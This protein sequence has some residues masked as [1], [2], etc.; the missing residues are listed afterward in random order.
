MVSPV[1]RVVVSLALLA[2]VLLLCG[3]CKTDDD[4]SSPNGRP[5]S[6]HIAT[7][8]IW[9]D[10]QLYV[11]VHDRT[12]EQLL[13]VRQ[14]TGTGVTTFPPL[15]ERI[16]VTIAQ[17]SED[18][19]DIR[20]YLD[21]PAGDWYMG[22][23]LQQSLRTHHLT[24]DITYPPGDNAYLS[25]GTDGNNTG[26][27]ISAEDSTGCRIGFEVQCSAPDSTGSI[28]GMVAGRDPGYCGW[29]LDLPVTASDC[30]HYALRLDQVA[31]MHT[32]GFSQPVRNLSVNALRGSHPQSIMEWSAN[33]Q[34]DSR[35]LSIPFCPEFPASKYFVA[36]DCYASMYYC[37]LEQ[38]VSQLPSS[39]TVPEVYLSATYDSYRLEVRD[40][41][42]VGTVDAIEA[43]WRQTTLDGPQCYWTVAARPGITT[44][45]RPT[46][47]DSLLTAFGIA[48][49]ELAPIGVSAEDYDV[50]HDFDAFVALQFRRASSIYT[51][52]HSHSYTTH[53][54]DASAA[55]EAIRLHHE[56]RRLR[57][58]GTSR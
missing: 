7:S 40:I 33:V 44:L 6:L 57:P 23:S 51:G 54:L 42:Y 29:L 21:V 49:V 37:S 27:L 25:L 30:T 17:I 18:Y 14:I 56:G 20:T 55:G 36:C 41:S 19:Q 12:G 9:G 10:S 53:Y 32:I 35:A 2:S 50:A 45:H 16:S 4:E 11:L 52:Y 31:E 39:V 5:F 38:L 47:P 48:Q 43:T 34:T 58:A 46:L 22:D 8:A 28:L 24:L 3:G 26:M 15:G 13:A 1:T